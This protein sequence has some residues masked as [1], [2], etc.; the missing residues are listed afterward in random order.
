M[1]DDIEAQVEAHIREI[2]RLARNEGMTLRK[3]NELAGQ[4]SKFKLQSITNRHAKVILVQNYHV[5]MG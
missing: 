1:T 2:L 5:K 4:T 3:L